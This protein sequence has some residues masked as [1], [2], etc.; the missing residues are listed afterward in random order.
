MVQRGACENLMFL[1]R[2]NSGAF[3]AEVVV[4]NHPPGSVLN[5]NRVLARI[6]DFNLR[7]VEVFADMAL[8]LITR[9]PYN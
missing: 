1:W 4:F 5:P 6:S 3:H 2:E 9:K 8:S 7:A